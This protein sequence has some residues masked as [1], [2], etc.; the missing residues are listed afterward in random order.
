[1]NSINFFGCIDWEEPAPKVVTMGEVINRAFE[2]K[3]RYQVLASNDESENEDERESVSSVYSKFDSYSASKFDSYSVTTNADNTFSDCL[4]L[5]NACGCC[6]SSRPN[7]SS[8]AS[9]QAVRQAAR[10]KMTAP[11]P[12]DVPPVAEARTEEDR[13]SR[14]VPDPLDVAHNTEEAMN[15]GKF[16]MKEKNQRSLKDEWNPAR[17]KGQ[18]PGGQKVHEA[19]RDEIHVLDWDGGEVMM[20]DQEIRVKVIQDSGAIA[21]VAR[22]D[23]IPGGVNIDGGNVKN[24]TAANGTSIKNYGKARVAMS[25]KF[26]NQSECLFNVADVT[27]NIHST[28]QICDQDFE[29]LY[30][31]KGCVVVPANFLSVH[32]TEQSAVARYPRE[33]GGLYVAEFTMRAPR[34]RSDSPGFTRQGAHP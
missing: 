16:Y 17:R 34:D 27:R 14:Q 8:K 6:D 12:L 20:A 24:F 3:N 9:K 28:G 21:H 4:K 2:T 30:T 1:M 19:K 18:C 7:G 10:Q 33:N 22:P 23:C 26:E 15:E 31:K 29:V 25:D 5:S 32:V 11:P 13:D